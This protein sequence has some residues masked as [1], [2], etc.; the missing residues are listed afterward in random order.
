MDLLPN[1]SVNAAPPAA[2]IR[3]YPEPAI[4]RQWIQAPD[5]LPNLAINFT[6][7]AAL[8][9]A[10]VEPTIRLRI[11]QKPDLYPN[12]AVNFP[13]V[14]APQPADWQPPKRYAPQVE[15]FQNQAIYAAV[16]A[17]YVPPLPIEPT[18]SVRYPPQV[19]E[20]PNL[21]IGVPYTPP[22]VV[23]P[24][25]TQT[26]A[27]RHKYRR[28]YVE[29][30]GQQFQ[31]DSVEDAVEILEKAKQIA[32]GSTAKAAAAMAVRR[33]V[34]VGDIPQPLRIPRIRADKEL[35]DV[36]ISARK[37]LESIYAN[38]L[39]EAE[40]KQR[41]TMRKREEDDDD[42]DLLLLL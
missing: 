15:V 13:Q 27:G 35:E 4:K 20:Y 33:A 18:I 25:T 17:P 29:I 10:P 9:I 5:V 31:V 12:I 16:Q 30:D 6:P 34:K 2:F 40:L 3:P 28:Y 37:E 26:P 38:A 1:L 11:A 7:P 8:V 21:V 36:V 24:V 41:L 42:D 19:I 39:L 32:Q 23:P 22:V 14:M